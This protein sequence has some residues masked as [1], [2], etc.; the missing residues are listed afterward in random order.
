MRGFVVE[1]CAL[2]GLIVGIW[3]GTHFNGRVA[4]WIG[5]DPDQ[6]VLSFIITLV[7]VL[8]LVHL[9][10]RA[11][12]K[13]LDLAQLGLP[14][15]IAGIVFGVVR[16]AFVI[17]VLLN[18]AFAKEQASW[19]PSEKTREG[20]RLYEPLRAFAPMIVPALKETKWVKKAIEQVNAEV[21]EATNE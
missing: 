11:I 3:A 15:K 12:T 4:Q 9:L 13:A 10:A 16:S 21:E 14:N 5:L 7:G 19:T 18:I 8:V 2:I 20:S 1:V 6:E 17:S